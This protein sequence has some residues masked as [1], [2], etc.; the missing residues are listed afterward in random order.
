MGKQKSISNSSL[1]KRENRVENSCFLL[2]AQTVPDFPEVPAWEFWEVWDSW[3]GLVW[4]RGLAPSGDGARGGVLGI[5]LRSRPDQTP[6]LMFEGVAELLHVRNGLIQALSQ[7]EDRMLGAFQG[8][9]ELF[10]GT[11]EVLEGD[12]DGAVIHK[13]PGDFVHVPQGI[14]Q[15]NEGLVQRTLFGGHF[16]QIFPQGVE[17]G[18]GLIKFPIFGGEVAE[19]VGCFLELLEGF[20]RFRGNRFQKFKHF[21]DRFGEIHLPF[22][23]ESVEV[24]S[25]AA[26]FV[27]LGEVHYKIPQHPDLLH[28]DGVADENSGRF[29]HADDH[30]HL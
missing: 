7:A 12:F 15:P 29:I 18:E 11:A 10:G 28:P 20:G 22:P 8:G 2:E 16:H 30:H 9:V 19:I 24:G 17:V 21:W 25:E 27:P 3:E 5:F 6:R 13:V 1:V 26:G 4:E 14:V 23:D